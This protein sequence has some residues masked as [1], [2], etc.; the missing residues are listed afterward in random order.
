MINNTD[1]VYSRPIPL[2]YPKVGQE[3]SGAKLGIIQLNTKNMHWIPL[4]GGEK[5]NYI[6]GM[7]WVNKDLLLIQQMNRKQ[8]QLLV[9]SYKPSTK[10]LK[11][12][13]TETEETWVDL[14][15]PDISSNSWEIT[16]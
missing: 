1:S 14:G 9:F 5:E 11:K 15:Y 2:Q 8:N 16:I 12:V 6:P 4:P 13:Y 10:E 7:Q 3:P